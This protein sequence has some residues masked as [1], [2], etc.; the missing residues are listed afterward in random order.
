[1]WVSIY[2]DGPFP[3]T[4]CLHSD[5]CKLLSLLAIDMGCI[6]YID[7]RLQ[8]FYTEG[9]KLSESTSVAS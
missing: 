5:F 8:L 6:D 4:G 3:V 2:Q 1:M 9:L 7:P